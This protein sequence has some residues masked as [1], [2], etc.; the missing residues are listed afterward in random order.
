MVSTDIQREKVSHGYES[1]YNA[2]W[3][4]PETVARNFVPVPQYYRLVRSESS[5]LLGPR[6]CG[7][8]TLLKMLTRP[9]LKTWDEEY[10]SRYRENPLTYP[11]FEAIYIPSD[12]RWSYE[13]KNLG[14]D[15]VIDKT[16][17][18]LTQRAMFSASFMMSLLEATGIL[19][20]R[21][22]ED[23]I[24]LCS[25]LI[26][27][28]K[29]KNT[30]PCLFDMTKSVSEI[31]SGIRGTLNFRD[32]D[33]LDDRLRNLP[34]LWFSHA[35]DLATESCMVVS[36]VLHHRIEYDQWA[37][38]FDEVEIAPDW[39]RNEL[40]AAT[41]SIGQKFIL[42][43]TSTPLL[44]SGVKSEPE[45]RNDFTPIRLW[46]SHLADARR[47]CREM[48]AD[49]VKKKFPNAYVTPTIFFSH[50]NSIHDDIEENIQRYDRNSSIYK[51]IKQLAS[52]DNSLY[53]LLERK[54]IDPK[55]PYTESRLLRSSVIRKIIPLV[56]L[57][58]AFVKIPKIGAVYR[59]S[60]LRSRK[61]PYIYSGEE[62]IYA[63]GEGNPRWLLGLL[64][65]LYD[66]WEANPSYRKNN[67]SPYIKFSV[68]ARVLNNASRIF[69]SYL[70]TVAWPKIDQDNDLYSIAD[71]LG[72]TIEAIQDEML[73]KTPFPADPIGSF[74]VGWEPPKRQKIGLEKALFLGA[75]VYIGKSDQAVPSTVAGG[76]FRLSFM[77]AP[78]YKLALRNYP[79]VDLHKL[80]SRSYTQ[81]DLFDEYQ[82]KY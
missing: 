33:L 65:D 77:L 39:L 27:L 80:L 59:R 25:A 35:V 21:S 58:L 79:A 63:M 36:K 14:Q 34:R 26:N 28:W 13:V 5:I 70:K 78:Q 45:A 56:L 29:L 11:E 42:K 4:T 7:K 62:A 71:F 16:T 6:G 30:A 37:L 68:Q 82:I 73:V 1:S 3:K 12:I 2:K 17:A 54:G 8:T 19:V 72:P 10:K 48:A 74:I 41:R 67:N 43:L 50:S 24:K 69:D 38:C 81:L 66:T 32:N 46:H 51:A 61:N 75:I 55:D 20:N 76:R 44:P 47:F 49:F 23:E 31:A 40:F 9:A 53:Q 15:E 52:L 22:T 57:R 60:Q 64:N 18:E